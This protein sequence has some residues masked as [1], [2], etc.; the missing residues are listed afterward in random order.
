MDLA[1]ICAT[2]REITIEGV[3]YKLV[4][5]TPVDYSLL[6]ESYYNARMKITPPE[7]Q[8]AIIRPKPFDIINGV[9]SGD[10]YRWLTPI[11]LR[12]S[13]KAGTPIPVEVAQR[14]TVSPGLNDLMYWIMLGMD[15]VAQV[16][17]AV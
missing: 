1:T 14:I 7:E 8:K 15:P 4:P 16:K 6:A 2:P 10:D 17:D 5:M 13:E 11:I 3:V 9:L 12:A